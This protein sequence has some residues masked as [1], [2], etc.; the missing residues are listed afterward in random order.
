MRCGIA[1]LIACGGLIGF[2]ATPAHAQF[3]DNFDYANNTALQATW[4]APVVGG[5]T[6][7]T[8]TYNAGSGKL[9]ATGMTDSDVGGFATATFNRATSFAGNFVARMEFDWNQS[10]T[11]GAM[12]MEVRSATGVIASGG[13]GDDTG[14][15][16][17]AYMQVGGA[18]TYL[19]AN[20]AYGPGTVSFE[21]VTG[22][23]ATSFNNALI[24]SAAA[25]VV[26]SGNSL[27]NS[28][29]ARLDIVRVGNMIS[30]R[31]D[32]GVNAFVLGPIAGSTDSVA[33]ISL[34]FGGFAYGGPTN[35]L[36]GDTGTHIGID[37]IVL[38]PRRNPG[39]ADGVNGITIADY[40]IIQANSF[41]KQPVGMNG[42]VNYDGVV[43]F[44][45]F[46]EWKTLFPGGVAAAEAAI[47]SLPEPTAFALLA[48]G[49]AGVASIRRGRGRQ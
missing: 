24:V 10:A 2:W 41:T 16:G 23:A 48:V 14:G 34:V 1:A 13:L 11:L 49:A 26:R 33:S 44:K 9:S 42:D 20:G 30:A 19:G 21:T 12:F 25:D 47:A 31:I 3:T 39:D 15:P 43:D 17:H 27:G 6:A 8:F 45:D 18:T 46:Q 28:G 38:E 36:V 32:N 22:A 37:K 4:G 5:T 40:Q 7:G 35:V 29:A